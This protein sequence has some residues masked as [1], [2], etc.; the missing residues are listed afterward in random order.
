MD[1]TEININSIADKILDSDSSSNSHS[2]SQSNISM[3]EFIKNHC[4]IANICNGVILIIPKNINFDKISSLL[5]NEFKIIHYDIQNNI[6]NKCELHLNIQHNNTAN[7]AKSDNAV[8][9]LQQSKNKKT[10]QTSKIPILKSSNIREK[11]LPIFSVSSNDDEKDNNNH[12]DLN[13]IEGLLITYCRTLQTILDDY[14]YKWGWFNNNFLS[15][16][17]HQMKTPLSGIFSGTQLLDTRLTSKE[18]RHI[19]DCLYKSCYEL[20]AYLKHII[21]YYVFTQGKAEYKYS[22]F[23]L[24]DILDESYNL[25]AE[26]FETNNTRY[27]YKF[28]NCSIGSSIHTD[29]KKLLKVMN[30]LISNSLKFTFNGDILIVIQYKSAQNEYIFNVFDTGNG[31]P[32]DEREHIFEPFYQVQS[33][34]LTHQ[35]GM[36]L[37][38]S[39]SKKIVEGLGGNIE[40]KSVVDLQEHSVN[41][42]EPYNDDG[43]SDTRKNNTKFT[44]VFEFNIPN[45]NFVSNNSNSTN[46]TNSVNSDT[47][48][49][50][51]N[52]QHNNLQSSHLSPRAIEVCEREMQSSP[53]MIP[54]SPVNNLMRLKNIYGVNRLKDYE[55]DPEKD[56]KNNKHKNNRDNDK[57]TDK[58]TDK[59]IEKRKVITKRRFIAKIKKQLENNSQ[60]KHKI[61]II[62]DNYNNATILK[63]LIET[64]GEY[65]V[66][67]LSN[68][69]EATDM[70]LNNGY[71]IVFLDLK[72]PKKSGFDI[73][74]ELNSCGFLSRQN[75]Y[76]NSIKTNIIITTALISADIKNKMAEYPSVDIL[77]KPL[78][79]NILR[80]IIYKILTPVDLDTDEELFTN[81]N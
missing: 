35:D 16:I 20:S 81:D 4:K 11:K 7:T 64:I 21:D 41:N 10:L 40:L 50:S 42:Y 8:N 48:D 19:I 3:N 69:L 54:N 6:D 12:N 37:G 44:T 77:Y 67:S 31:I 63:Y 5:D 71:S 79:G 52:H 78:D 66:S 68:P 15:N 46:S 34:W 25:L 30:N 61:L 60:Q 33:N 18:D 27:N 75:S 70:I 73:L 17:S 14:K 23:K 29:K 13:T 56:D 80:N 57:N 62:D 43:S 9:N 53:I 36:G 51:Q 47:N 55:N 2:H 72:M 22:T 45:H 28:I 49:R 58:N 1:A 32:D 59:D 76:S 38:L 24:C 65:D 74:D 39:I 26:Q